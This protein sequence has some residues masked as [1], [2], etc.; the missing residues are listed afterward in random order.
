M[1]C[2]YGHCLCRTMQARSTRVWID[3]Q[4]AARLRTPYYEDTV[5][6]TFA[7]HLNRNHPAENHV[8]VF[9]GNAEGKNGSDFIWI[10]F[11][12]S[13]KRY[14]CVA[15]QAKQLYPSGRYDAFKIHQ[16]NKIRRYAQIAGAIPL[17]LTYNYPRI[18]QTP[19]VRMIHSKRWWPIG[20]L[21]CERDLGLIYLH[22]DHA[23]NI[24]DRQL[25][26]SHIVQNGLPIWTAFCTCI[27]SRTGDHLGDLQKWLIAQ[28]ANPD[29]RPDG[30]RETPSALRAWK[31]GQDVKEQDLLEILELHETTDRDGFVPSF[32]LGT[33]LRI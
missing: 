27:Y 2:P 26:P 24:G 21:D 30:L 29:R 15:V 18:L 17:Y 23:R 31:T 8:H 4:D 6:Q 19:F 5:T 12:D 7:L 28:S 25:S 14:F 32:V 9:G 10:F 11:D 20:T 13:L 3:L 16:V 33:T 22:A 1:N